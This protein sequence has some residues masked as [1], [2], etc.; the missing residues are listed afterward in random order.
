MSVQVNCPNCGTSL[1]FSESAIGRLGHCTSCGSDFQIQSI[2]SLARSPSET[3]IYCSK[4]GAANP[5][6]NY[7]CLKCNEALHQP[8]RAAP[9]LEP[10][11]SASSLSRANVS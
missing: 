6:N 1:S 4:C 5:E 8:A 3:M 11:R 9:G 7:R 10:N 2:E